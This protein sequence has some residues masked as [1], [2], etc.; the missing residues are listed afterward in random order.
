MTAM[1]IPVRRFEAYEIAPCIPVAV[2]DGIT[3]YERQD[4]LRQLTR[5]ERAGLIWSLYGWRQ[6]EGVQCIGDFQ[7][8]QH[9]IEIY[10]GITGHRVAKRNRPVVLIGRPA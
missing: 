3:C 2:N 8:Q 4:D 6:G 10:S 9:A 1:R 5:K 7:K